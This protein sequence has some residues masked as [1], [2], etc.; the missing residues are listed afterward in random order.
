MTIDVTQNGFTPNWHVNELEAREKNIMDK[1]S[2]FDNLEDA[3]ER[4]QKI[5][6]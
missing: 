5:A 3:K 1:K 6:F 4:L 2:S